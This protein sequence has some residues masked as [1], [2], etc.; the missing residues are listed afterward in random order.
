MPESKPKAKKKKI[1]KQ[2]PTRIMNDVESEVKK[3][4][5]ETCEQEQEQAHFSI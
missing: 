2:N 3:V 1:R 4:K 5:Q